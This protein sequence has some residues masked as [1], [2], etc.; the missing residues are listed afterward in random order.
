[1]TKR[2]LAILLILLGFAAVLGIL[3]WTFYPVIQDFFQPNTEQQPAALPNKNAPAGG[4]QAPVPSGV[5]PTPPNAAQMELSEQ[6]RQETVK[7]FASQFVAQQ[8]SYSNADGYAAILTAELLATSDVRAW[9]EDQRKQ[10]LVQHPQDGTAY[11]Q[12]TLA[13]ATKLVTPAP[14]KGKTEVQVSVQAQQ[15]VETSNNAAGRKV[16]YLD[17]SVTAK[18]VSGA[19]VVSRIES[20]PF[21]P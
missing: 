19:W 10:L 8:G 15:T 18:L 5:R 20:K 11:G 7:R 9:L 3:A 12:T 16:S 6:Q 2:T 4:T 14:I 21:Q 13:L 1:M 17:Y